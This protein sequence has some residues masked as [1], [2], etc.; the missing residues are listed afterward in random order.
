[1][2]KRR[3]TLALALA[4][5]FAVA[6]GAFGLPSAA[7]AA[8][9]TITK[10]GA[11]ID[12]PGS[13]GVW[14]LS[15]GSY[16]V[17]G[18][19]DEGESIECSG[20]VA[21]T[22]NGVSIVGADSATTTEQIL[23]AMPAVS[24]NAGSTSIV[25]NGD[26]TV[27]G[28]PGK[29]GIFVARGAAVDISG[30]GSLVARGGAGSDVVRKVNVSGY[31]SVY[32]GAG[33]GIGGNG[34]LVS[35]SDK[36][37]DETGANF[38]SVT[39][40]GGSV[41]AIG[42]RAGIANAG[43]GAGI[44]TGGASTIYS[45]DLTVSGYVAISGGTVVATGGDGE[46]MSETGGGAGI[47]A[48]G[49]TGA[50][51]TGNSDVTVAVSAGNVTASGTAD[52]AGIGGG[53][54]A[55]AGPI[56]ISG[57][58]VKTTGGYETDG[59]SQDGAYGGAGIGGGDNGTFSS[60][61]ISGGQV[62]A[63]AIGAA[64]GIGGGN[65]GCSGGTIVIS[66][67]ADV[68]AYGG[69]RLDKEQGGAGIGMGRSYYNDGGFESLKIGDSAKVRAYA[70]KAA[71][72]IGVGTS[73]DGDDA[74]AISVSGSVDVWAFNRDTTSAAILGSALTT[75][76]LDLV[77]FAV[78]DPSS[79]PGADVDDAVT[80][81]SGKAYAWR[82]TFGSEL[83][84]KDGESV[85]ASTPY[86]S[87]YTV[88]NWATFLAPAKKTVTID[89]GNGAD[90][91]TET[92]EAG[93]LVDKPAD[94]MREGYRFD[95]W[96]ADGS[97]D[98]FDFSQPITSDVTLHAK[99][100]RVHAV[101][102]VDGQGNKT[103]TAVDDGATMPRPADPTYPGKTFAG[104]WASRDLSGDKFDFSQPITSDVTLYPGWYDSGAQGGNDGNAGGSGNDASNGDSASA[105]DARALP[106]T[107]DVATPIALVSAAA[108]AALAGA[109]VLRHRD[110]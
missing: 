103:T 40:S 24:V 21:L 42:G 8:G 67:A 71:Q 74:N 70:G 63:R 100:V 69:S 58:V 17:S 62:T 59:G 38:G 39:I 79:V 50:F 92:V 26:N 73:Y 29:A 5:T 106:Q 9:L 1:M 36:L 35:G 109:F 54:N 82:H 25:L 110:A 91:V 51:Y 78:S 2:R 75:D 53:A 18:T 48:G 13:N 3:G 47:G 4:T 14:E 93:S 89:F 23:A 16:E 41:T 10:D 105:G 27:Q 61:E 90:S 72:G 52:G 64:A 68:A 83:Q 77:S 33:A 43:G 22:L 96:Y 31:T 60:I 66:G 97:D 99:W 87:S 94:P 37:V 107:G 20:D 32:W 6:A 57:G 98:P 81:A 102:V 49:M 88:G 55:S 76:G 15:D 95:G 45:D 30:S 44:G 7:W 101:T 19:A 86:D 84:V 11:A 108:S 65:D 80:S 104:W 46:E 56:A 28:A 12:G 85:V 34:D